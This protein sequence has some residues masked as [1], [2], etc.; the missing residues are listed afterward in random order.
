MSD[1]PEKPVTLRTKLTPIYAQ[2]FGE[3][4]DQ[5]AVVET[6][7]TCEA[8][9]MCDHGQLAPVAMDY[10]VPDAKC[11]TFH[12]TLANYAVGAILA[13]QGDELAEGRRRLRAKIAAR[14][15]VTP[16]GIASPRRYNVLYSAARGAGFFGRSKAML[17]PYFDAENDGRCTVWLHRDA[18]C[19]TYFCKYTA[20]KPG[21]LFW[22]SLKS[23]ITF[24]ER[25]LSRHT[26]VG[27]DP[28]VREPPYDRL[29]LSKEDLEDLPP[30]DA[31]YAS[32]WGNGAWVGREEEFYVACYQRVRDM[33]R[34]AF[35]EA[36][37]D[38]PDGRGYLG[39][40]ASRYELIPSD[41][42]PKSLVLV[43]PKDLQK[44]VT[45][46][47][48]VVTTYNPYDA[49]S[50]DKELFDVLG[51]LR[52]EETL[53]ENLRRLDRDHDVQLAPELV[54]YLYVHGVLVEP[55]ASKAAAERE[56]RAAAVTPSVVLTTRQQRRAAKRRERED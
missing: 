36:V 1:T 30:T 11:C 49:F 38:T 34:S 45:E 23:Y 48:V 18:V 16:N 20:G 37:D 42:T 21:F 51:M 27:L 17:C 32:Y 33:P 5:P 39:R 31:D 40:L 43:A 53:E 55:E 19:S 28:S 13:D 25:T 14:V 56:R 29:S 35:V 24:V 4:F 44:R 22:D 52:P 15:G 6:R 2:L 46:D 8:C 10:F 3:V 9:S 47:A 50:V 41:E 12:P 26:A 54:H 7:A